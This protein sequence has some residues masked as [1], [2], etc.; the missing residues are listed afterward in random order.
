MWRAAYRLTALPPHPL[1]QR[2]RRPRSRYGNNGPC[3][4]ARCRE[5]RTFGMHLDDSAQRTNF[6]CPRDFGG[7]LRPVAR[8]FLVMTGELGLLQTGDEDTR[9]AAPPKADP[10]TTEDYQGHFFYT[11]TKGSARGQS[12]LLLQGANTSDPVDPRC[13]SD[14][15]LGRG[16][17][18]GHYHS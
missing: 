12:R 5:G 13:R 9:S 2:R 4:R 18:E 14:L 8:L 15:Q 11:H 7:L 10:R 16:A 1:P 3:V 6:T 17:I